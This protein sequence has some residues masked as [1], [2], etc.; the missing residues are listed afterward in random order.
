MKPEEW[1]RPGEF[2]PWYNPKPRIPKPSCDCSVC[3]PIHE[4]HCVDCDVKWI[5]RDPNQIDWCWN[6]A[7]VVPLSLVD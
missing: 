3:Y 2:N 7:S 6:C 5:S 4:Y 1:R